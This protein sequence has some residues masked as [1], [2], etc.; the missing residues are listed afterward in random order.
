[1]LA[2]DKDSRCFKVKLADFG[3]AEVLPASGESIKK[4]GAGTS[5]YTAPE[6]QQNLPYGKAS[7]IWSLGCLLYVMVSMQLPQGSVT[8]AEL[9]RLDASLE[10]KDLI[11][12]L[13]VSSPEDRPPIEMIMK[14]P[15]F[16]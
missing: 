14:H 13:L 2:E 6:V 1:M 11:G 9:E 7:D 12:R 8:L 16:F 3:I 5:G 4:P 10:C 15:F